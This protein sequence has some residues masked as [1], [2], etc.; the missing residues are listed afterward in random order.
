VFR[1]IAAACALSAIAL[2]DA[3]TAA[4]LAGRV[5]NAGLDPAACYRVL[6]LNFSREDIHV[7][8]TSGYLIFGK[9]VD[10][11]RVTAVYSA[12]TEDGDAE[13]LLL[14]PRRSERL[15]LATFAH[16][17]NLE[18]HFRSALL[19]FTDTTAQELLAAVQKQEAERGNIRAP[20]MG[21]LLA[22]AWD[23]TV[24][25]ISDSFSIRLV[26]DLLSPGRAAAGL[27]FMAIASHN[28]GNFDVVYDPQNSDQITVGQFTHRADRSIFDVWTSFESR[29]IRNGSRQ[30]P[31]PPFTL[32]DLHID[33]TISRDLSMKATTRATIEWNSA[34]ARAFDFEISPRVRVTE[35]RLD[36]EPAEVFAPESLRDTAIRGSETEPFLIVAPHPLDPGHPHHIEIHH[37]GSVITDAGNGVYYVGAR[38][39]WYPH[40]GSQFANYD[41]TFHYPADLTLV[42][43]GNIVDEKMEQTTE[44]TMRI[45]HRVTSAPVRMAG[46]NLGRYRKIVA[47]HDPYT[48]EVYG[49]RQLETALQPKEIF[50][51][52]PIT[53]QHR[54]GRRPP[55]LP[56]SQAVPPAPPDPAARLHVIASEVAAAFDYMTVQFGPASLNT[57]TVAPIPGAFGQGF[58]GLVY[59]STVSYLNPEQRPLSARNKTT[60]VFFSDLLVAH[61]VAHQW[62]GN[63]VTAS[64]YRDSWLMEALANYTALLYLEKRKGARALDFVLDHYRT[65]LLAKGRDGRSIESAGPIT[66]GVRLR[67]SPNEDAWRAI[68][69][70]KGAWI[71]HMLR[72]RMGDA[73]FSHM[74]AEICRRY[75][76]RGLSTTD[77]HR[78]AEHFL[79]SHS[80]ES[81]LDNFFDTWIYDT[82]IPTLKLS[83]SVR[84]KAPALKLT[85]TITQTG[86]PDDFSIYAPVEIQTG[87]ATPLVHW[88]HTASGPTSFTVTVNRPPAKVSLSSENI[89]AICK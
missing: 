20:E 66:W 52:D 44:G 40:H 43:T 32:A 22:G 48:I 74:L 59:L 39:A 79:P 88:V 57:L 23:S 75:R 77:F 80:P 9:P 86:V 76:Y 12:E 38:D 89:L 53:T 28:F 35:A 62:W 17:P 27:L 50:I 49:N 24:R 8:F 69:Y 55:E 33:A 78:I 46:F 87:R 37:Q 16:V 83:Y 34:P 72:R 26:Q 85:V 42:S 30:A 51:P 19:V 67:G 61:E 7:Y 3:P 13:L 18:E 1:S 82:G 47:R 15:S 2:A 4:Q 81:T 65:E 60:Q 45:T 54:P 71:L 41:L 84:G 5:H 10:G 63:L 58:P 29:S 64:S 70:E 36:G 56:I 11:V 73:A 31:E 68:V 25:N 14:P 6:N 21:T